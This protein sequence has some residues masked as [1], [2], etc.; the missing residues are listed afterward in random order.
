[1]T[2]HTQL[3][4]RHHSEPQSRIRP[5]MSVVDERSGV[6]PD[7]NNGKSKKRQG[8]V[9]PASQWLAYLALFAFLN[10]IWITR[11]QSLELPNREL[12]VIMKPPSIRSSRQHRITSSMLTPR[13][14]RA[15]PFVATPSKMLSPTASN[16]KSQSAERD[17]LSAD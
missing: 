2:K 10:I 3:H 15:R 4:H 8:L 12:P 17:N 14:Q 1:M 6:A 5:R 16:H 11:Q 9:P 7:S 13:R